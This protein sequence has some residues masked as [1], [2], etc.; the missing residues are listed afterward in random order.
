MVRISLAP[1][2]VI[3]DELARFEPDVVH[4]AS[5]FVVGGS[6]LAAAEELSVPVVAV[7]KTNMAQYP[8]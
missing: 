1:T 3:A 5:P 4:V 6:A 7:Y 8:S 2:R